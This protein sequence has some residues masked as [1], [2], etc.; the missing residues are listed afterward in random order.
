MVKVG[1]GSLE[2]MEVDAEI[3]VSVFWRPNGLSETVRD[4]VEKNNFIALPG[5]WDT[6][7]YLALETV[8]PNSGE[9]G[10]VFYSNV[11]RAGLLIRIRYV[12]RAGAGLGVLHLFNLASG[13]LLIS[14]EC[15][16]E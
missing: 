2:R 7:V 9:F 12:S 3:M 1:G 10:E 8:Y 14:E 15:F 4:E 11:S 6:G 16:I 5:E 13:G